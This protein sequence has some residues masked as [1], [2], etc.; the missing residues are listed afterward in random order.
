VVL[1]LAGL[2]GGAVIGGVLLRRAEGPGRQ[3]NT[4]RSSDDTR[5]RPEDSSPAERHLTFPSDSANSAGCGPN[6]KPTFNPG[7]AGESTRLR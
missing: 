2:A 7:V 4:S 1:L 6:R 5:A 3:E